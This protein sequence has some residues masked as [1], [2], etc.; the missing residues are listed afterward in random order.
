MSQRI[1]SETIECERYVDALRE[2]NSEML[3]ALKDLLGDRSS[4]Q[5]GICQHCGRDYIGD[6]LE[7]DCPS[8]DCPSYAARAIIAKSEATTPLTA[9]KTVTLHIKGGLVQDVTGVPDGDE[10]RLEDYDSDDTSH[11]SW[12]AQKQCVVTIYEGASN[13]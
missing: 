4:V 8:D 13:G 7:G 2:S 5:G 3:A 1:P 6:V 11:P 10:L 12:D 9:A